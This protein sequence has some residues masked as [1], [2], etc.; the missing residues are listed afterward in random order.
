MRT[1][2]WSRG[3]SVTVKYA[4]PR[5]CYHAMMKSL[6]KQGRAAQAGRFAQA[7]YRGDTLASGGPLCNMPDM[8]DYVDR[9]ASSS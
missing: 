5:L 6:V 3:K 4:E 7:C 1:P 2:V 8:K 9:A